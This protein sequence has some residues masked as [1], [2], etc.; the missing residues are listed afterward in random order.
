MQRLLNS[1]AIALILMVFQPVQTRGQTTLSDDQ[2]IIE[3]RNTLEHHTEHQHQ[4]SLR[5]LLA[6]HPS[7]VVRWNPVTLA[8]GSLMYIYQGIISPQLHNTCIHSPSCSSFSK[9]LF[10]EYGLIRGLVFTADRIS[11]CNRLALYDTPPW[12]VDTQINKIREDIQYYQ[13][14][15]KK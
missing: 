1:A 2:L 15:L 8:L 5:F 9:S 6:D 4:Q 10:Q 3:H 11:R 7:A 14:D 13:L 12:E